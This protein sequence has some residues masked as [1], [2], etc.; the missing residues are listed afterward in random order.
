MLNKFGSFAD[1][2]GWLGRNKC[3]VGERRRSLLYAYNPMTSTSL[4]DARHAGPCWIS[5]LLPI[6]WL[7]L[8]SSWTAV[9]LKKK[10]PHQQVST[11]HYRWNF[12][13]WVWQPWHPKFCDKD[14][15]WTPDINQ[16]T[17]VNRQIRSEMGKTSGWICFFPPYFIYPVT[18][19]QSL[20]LLAGVIDFNFRRWKL[21]LWWKEL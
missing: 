21:F 17:Q 6:T 9:Q 13:P 8:V 14:F 11:N 12:Q 18:W 20:P 4:S 7:D 10:S 15:P 3:A 2:L 1:S 19:R 16:G 5:W